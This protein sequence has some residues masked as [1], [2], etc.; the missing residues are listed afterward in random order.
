MATLSSPEGVPGTMAVPPAGGAKSGPS[1]CT[2][3]RKLL[4]PGVMVVVAAFAASA[5]PL[6][7]GR[8]PPTLVVTPPVASPEQTSKAPE[9]SAKLIT[10]EGVPAVNAAGAGNRP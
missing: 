6:A 2:N 9:Q 4:T 10:I 5:M 1:P 8:V 7:T 3:I